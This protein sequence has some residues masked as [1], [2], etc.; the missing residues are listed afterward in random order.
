MGGKFTR[1]EMCEKLFCSSCFR[2]DNHQCLDLTDCSDSH[3]W[4][5]SIGL[6][7][8]NQIIE[9]VNGIMVDNDH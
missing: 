8:A 7:I 5:N 2:V 1:C 6:M 3:G 9:M 4:M